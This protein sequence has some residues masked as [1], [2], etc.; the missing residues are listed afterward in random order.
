M[1]EPASTNQIIRTGGPDRGAN[2]PIR[3][4][5]VGLLVGAA[6]YIGSLIG[7]AL[8]FPDSAVSV[9]WPPNAIVFTALL[10]MPIRRWWVVLLGVFPVHVAVQL[11]SGVPI[12]LILFWFIS[13]AAEALIGAICLRRFV[14]RQTD[15]AGLKNL[16]IYLAVAILAPFL[17]SFIDASFVSLVGWKGNTYWQ[18]WLMRFPSN[19]LAALMIPPLAILWFDR[20]ASFLRSISWWRGAEA[21]ILA[22]GLI[23][24][25]LTVF[26][27]ATVGPGALTVLIYLPLPFF[28]WA[29][30]R[31]GQLGASTA[32]LLVVMTSICG[33]FQGNGPF[34]SQFPARNVLSLQLFLIAIVLPMMFLAA[35][36]EEQKY[37]TEVVREIK[38]W[39]AAFNG[40]RLSLY[41]SLGLTA[42][43]M[44][45]AYYFGSLVDLAFVYPASYFSA[46][47]PANAVLLA[48]LLLN[49]PRY[50][51]VFLLA[52]AVAHV[53]AQRQF[54]TPGLEL[55]L[56]YLYDCALVAVTAL[57]VRQFGA[58]NG[59]LGNLRRS[60]IFVGQITAAT[61]L[62][63]WGWPLIQISV[64]YGSDNIWLEW[65]HAFLSNLLPFLILTP[66]IVLGSTRGAEIIKRASLKQWMEM[67][68]ILAGVLGSGIG[69]FGL[70]SHALGN[71]PALLYIP[72]PFLLWAAVRLGLVGLSLSFLA[73]AFMTM[74][75]ALAGNGPFVSQLPADN[76]FWLQMFL[77]V[78]YFPLLLLASLFEERFEKIQILG[79]TENRFRNLADAAPIMIWVSNTDKLCSFFSKGWLDFT[80]RTLDQELGNGWSEGVHPDDLDRCLRTYMES[81]DRRQDFS[82]EYRLRRA[83]GEYRWILNN[84]MARFGPDGIFLGYMGSAVDISERKQAE[85]RLNAQYDITRILSESASM[86][87]AAPKILQSICSCLDWQYGEIWQVDQGTNI[88]TSRASWHLPSQDLAEF[89]SASRQVTFAPG[90]GSPGRVWQ[91]C[92]PTWIPDVTADNN[93]SRKSLAAEA[94]LHSACAFPIHRGDEAFGVMGFFSREIR[95]PDEVLLQMMSNV[96]SQMGL[97]V[98]RKRAERA[99]RES[100]ARLKLA[101]ESARMGYWELEVDTRKVTRSEGLERILGVTPGSLK[102]NLADFLAM[103]HPEDREK[104]R[105]R[106]ER[107]LQTTEISDSEYRIV[108]PDGSI[109]WIAGRGH[110]I[111]GSDG[112]ASVLLGLSTDITERKQVEEALRDSESLRRTIFESEP[113]CVKLVAP[114]TR[115]LDMNPAGLAIIQAD[116][117]DDVVGQSV[118]AIVAPEWRATYKKLHDRVCQGERGVAQFEIVGLKGKRRWMESHAAPLR[119]KNGSIVA[120]LA[121]SHDITDR[122]RAEEELKEALAEVGRLKERLEAENVYLR[123]EVSGVHRYGEILGESKEIEKVLEQVERVA[124]T[125]MTVL[126]LGETGTGKELVARLLHEKSG[127][128]ERPLVK[129]N[130]SALP[131][132][133]IESELFGH[134]RGAFTGAVSKQV[135]RFELADGGTIFL[136]EVGELPLRLQ[137]KLLR[138]LQEGEFE[139]VGSGKTVKVDVRVIAAT[140]RNLSEAAQRGR[141]RTDL[142]YRLNVYPI[143]IPPLRERRED[144]GILAEVFLQ[145]AGRRLGKSFGQIPSGVIEAL[146]GYSWPG[147]VREL[148]NVIGRA[149][150]TSTAPTLQLP[151]G[152]NQAQGAEIFSHASPSGL[153]PEKSKSQND[154]G[155]LPLTLE[156][157]ERTRILKVLHQTNWRIEGPKGAAVILGLHPNTLRSRMKKLEIH[158]LAKAETV[159]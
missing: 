72:L 62:M 142:Y 66:G 97:F 80:G 41:L 59:D 98:E 154:G 14:E 102:S 93:F 77:I 103:V 99:L 121:V 123:S 8:T 158:R 130:C 47:W 34:L 58:I 138:V 120:Q 12:L 105:L 137:S 20:G 29:A 78:L 92:Q 22:F 113:E 144:I 136:D 83:D 55:D 148:E 122:K 2:S 75:N 46:L 125:D 49:P 28:L 112:H 86:A 114:D 36:V 69:V 45:A 73:F 146:Q 40:K 82:M 63:A 100:E 31:F 16:A 76:I 64:G 152:W 27:W 15:F 50:W 149:T 141:F 109:R 42:I 70:K 108:R 71:F 145:E 30:V 24:T 132:E 67:I 1:I 143:E 56:Y 4:L 3:L 126:V 52:G 89:W 39:S 5:T 51:S 106:A 110:A 37:K 7:F 54:G 38:P 57:A 117:L 23:T 131:A 124:R 91:T 43:A 44:W 119:A 157:F 133:L 11:Q 140:N 68:V 18:T 147:N 84:G 104:I 79:E 107:A 111:F 26:C 127:R 61:A 135:G 118:L 53:V 159:G 35:F 156:E 85:S 19:V 60:I 74:L 10:L 150:V 96:G 101:M 17:G 151:E 153:T 25:G 21:S 32:F 155:E 134:E 81:F 13:N 94:G 95:K 90:V 9:L 65:R 87:E 33:A 139:R 88:L 48:A 115:L 129:V 116:S 128:R 6:Y